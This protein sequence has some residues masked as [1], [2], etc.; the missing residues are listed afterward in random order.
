MEGRDAL[1]Y[2]L[3]AMKKFSRI[4]RFQLMPLAILLVVIASLCFSVGEGLRFTPFTPL[5]LTEV[6][7]INVL[8]DG[9]ATSETSLY[10]H[11]PLDVPTKT[12]RNKRQSVHLACTPAERPQELL[13]DLCTS[14]SHEVV[15]IGSAPFGSRPS[16]RA[17]PFIS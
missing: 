17:P 12:Q 14:Y 1:W 7:A 5:V 4:I 13:P 3:P 9:K 8:V 15:L 6:K 2:V 11:G 16:G 10:K